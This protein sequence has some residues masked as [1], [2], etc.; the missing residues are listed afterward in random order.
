MELVSVKQEVLEEFELQREEQD[1]QEGK[2]TQHIVIHQIT[3]II[4]TP[5]SAESL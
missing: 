3:F 4:H 1:E 2:K 5:L